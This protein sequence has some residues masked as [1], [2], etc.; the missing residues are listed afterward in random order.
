LNS[1]LND[2]KIIRWQPSA[3]LKM[4]PHQKSAQLVARFQGFL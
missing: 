3:Y 1:D 2:D 4:T